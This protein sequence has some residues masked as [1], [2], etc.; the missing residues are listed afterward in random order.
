MM[1]D[2]IN[3][4]K[5]LFLD[6][7]T[8]PEVYKYDGLDEAKAKLFE[9]KERFRIEKAEIETEEHYF[10]RAGILAEFGKIVCVSIGFFVVGPNGVEF[11]MKSF[12][13][14]NEKELLTNL[15]K[16]L[17][18][19]FSGFTLCG[20]NIKEFDVPYICRRA[21]IN[22]LKLPDS[23]QLFGKKPWEVNLLDSM[24]LWRCGGHLPYP[25]KS[26]KTQAA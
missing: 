23:I 24:E 22:G 8:V 15:F 2:K 11:R 16:L 21:L 5:V 14:E 3:L 12:I 7:E 9:Q 20:H 10:E 25:V 17:S 26:S 18:G 19:Y 13:E 6:I 1:I 4:Q